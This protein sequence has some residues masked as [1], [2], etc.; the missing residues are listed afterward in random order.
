MTDISD[1]AANTL[2]DVAPSPTTPAGFFPNPARRWGL[3]IPY[4]QWLPSVPPDPNYWIPITFGPVPSAPTPPYP[5]PETPQGD[6]ALTFQQ[7]AFGTT[8]ATNPAGGWFSSQHPLQLGDPEFCLPNFLRLKWFGPRSDEFVLDSPRNIITRTLCDTDGDGF[9]DS[10]WFLAPTSIDRSVRNVV[11]VSVVDNSALINVNVATRFNPANTGGK[12]PADVALVGNAIRPDADVV[13]YPLPYPPQA[14]SRVGYLDT[15]LNTAWANTYE[16][17][18]P[19]FFVQFDRNRFG[20]LIGA[21][22]ALADFRANPTILSEL[23][24]V[25]WR[26]SGTPGAEAVP[27]FRNL[28]LS[29][30]ERTT[31]FK[32]MARDGE[33][34]NYFALNPTTTNFLS[35]QAAGQGD[36]VRF[37][38]TAGSGAAA[39]VRTESNPPVLLDPFTMADEY[40]LRAFHGH[41]SPSLRSRLERAVESEFG[42]GA[43]PESQPVNLGGQFLRS[44]LIREETS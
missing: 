3:E 7:L 26:P 37:L 41:N 8:P 36:L 9:T 27:P 5:N 13:T 21:Q 30:L 1:V 10:F 24:V 4:E 39:T 22:T 18:E 38:A 28:L 11:G 42:Q 43:V 35:E 25:A 31:Y 44:A 14:N 32:A 34:E 20:G 29:D 6:A 16:P 40:E 17:N 33:V 19:T 15:D 23:G 12:T 2:T